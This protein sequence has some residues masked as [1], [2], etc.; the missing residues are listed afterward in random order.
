MVLNVQFLG[1]PGCES[2]RIKDFKVLLVSAGSIRV[3]FI[4]KTWKLNGNSSLV[5]SGLHEERNMFCSETPMF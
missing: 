3:G 2:F 1:V 4:L 5:W